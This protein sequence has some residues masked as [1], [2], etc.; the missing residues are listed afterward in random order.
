MNEPTTPSDEISLTVKSIGNAAHA[1]FLA[2]FCNVPLKEKTTD[3]GDGLTAQ[4]IHDILAPVFA[5][6]FLDNDPAKSYSNRVVAYREAQKFAAVMRRVVE[7]VKTPGLLNT[8]AGILNTP[9][10]DNSFPGAGKEFIARLLE[11]NPT[12]EDVVWDLI[13]TQAP[14]AANQAATV[15]W[16]LRAMSLL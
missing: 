3:L 10:S 11:S 8:V 12:V 5:Y 1:T 14:A 16:F 6:V 2:K 9:A 15:S 4:E 13:P 7:R